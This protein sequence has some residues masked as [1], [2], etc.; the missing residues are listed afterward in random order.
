MRPILI[1]S[2]VYRFTDLTR[3]NSTAACCIVR[4]VM[5][6][7]NVNSDTTWASIDNWYWRAAEVCIGIVAACIPTLRPAYR[8]V[9]AGVSAYF[10][11]RSSRQNSGFTLVEPRKTRRTSIDQKSEAKQITY[12]Q[13]SYNAAFGAAAQAVSAEAGRAEEFGVGEEGFPMKSLSG[14]KRT[15]DQGIKKTTRIEID[16]KSENMGQRSLEVGD[17]ERGFRNRDFL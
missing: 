7:Q 6:W 2:L 8:M 1:T 15:A 10:S 17:V 13:A 14:D 3:W 11:R 12:P 4:T 16:R 9:S 5:N